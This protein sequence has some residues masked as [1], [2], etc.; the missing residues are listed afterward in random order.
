MNLASRLEGATR[1]LGVGIL[2]TAESAGSFARPGVT[3]RPLG[4]V[5]VKGRKAASSLVEVLALNGE[6][7]GAMRARSAPSLE[8]A[9]EAFA[10]GA[11]QAAASDLRTVVDQNPSDGPA[12]R[13]LMECELRLADAIH[14][15]PLRLESK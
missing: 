6:D 7:G 11:Y 8:R 2:T 4:D 13:Y 10:R 3:L 12:L 14:A 9:L 5:I 1:Q 15:G